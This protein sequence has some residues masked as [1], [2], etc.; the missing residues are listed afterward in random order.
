MSSDS[1]DYQD[2]ELVQ[3]TSFVLPNPTPFVVRTQTFTP[4]PPPRRNRNRTIFDQSHLVLNLD[5]SYRPVPPPRQNRQPPSY[6]RL[7][8]LNSPPPSYEVLFPPPPRWRYTFEH[9]ERRKE[10]FHLLCGIKVSIVWK[11]IEN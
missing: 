10:K 6:A 3:V 5:S 7:F 11:W 4:I 9:S 1:E 8:G 2:V